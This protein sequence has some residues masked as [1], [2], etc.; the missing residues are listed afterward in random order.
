MEAQEEAKSGGP[1]D[2]PTA[3]KNIQ[4]KYGQL[5]AAIGDMVLKLELLKEEHKVLHKNYQEALA[6]EAKAKA[7]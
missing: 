4:N 1:A 2:Q 6:E 5:C 3:V 7:P